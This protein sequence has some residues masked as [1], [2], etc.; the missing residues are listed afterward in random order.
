[1]EENYVIFIIQ[2]L[3]N[4]EQQ[5]LLAGGEWQKVRLQHIWDEPTNDTLFVK[6]T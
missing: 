5:S 1:M 3:E 2:S 4:K 6:Y